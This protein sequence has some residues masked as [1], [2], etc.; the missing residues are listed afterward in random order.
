MLV[1]FWLKNLP[2]KYN[3]ISYVPLNIHQVAKHKTLCM[4]VYVLDFNLRK[5]KTCA[6]ILITC[7][8]NILKETQL[9]SLG[10]FYLA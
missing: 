2:I 1:L 3:H 8:L 5:G 10:K 7:L 9:C 6:F 4:C